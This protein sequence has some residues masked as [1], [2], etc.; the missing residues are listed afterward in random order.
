MLN[1]EADQRALRIAA[2]Q[3]VVMVQTSEDHLDAQAFNRLLQL[4]GDILTEI[5]DRRVED[6]G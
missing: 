3:I 6:Q 4:R 5:H 2:L 1:Q